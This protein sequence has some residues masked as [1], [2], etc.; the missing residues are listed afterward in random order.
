MSQP[1]RKIIAIDAMGGDNAPEAV[2]SALAEFA[3]SG[4]HFLIFGNESIREMSQRLLPKDLSYEIRYS[5]I[6]VTSDMDVMSSLRSMKDST[7]G[8]AIQ[9][10]KSGKADA[11]ISA[12]NTGLYM[13]LSK[14]ILRT[15]PG[16]DRPAIATLVPGKD[17][18]TVCLDLGANAE[19]SVKNLLDFAIVGEALARSIFDKEDVSLA[20]LNI[21][22][23]ENK[24]TELVKQTAVVL[25]KMFD[26]YVGFV[27]GD[28][29]CKGKVDVIVTDGFTGNVFLKSIEGVAK[30]IS[31]ELKETLAK[32]FLSKLGA[33]LALPALVKFRKKMDP[34]LYNGGMLL[35][36]NGI[37]VKSHGGTDKV[38]F[39]SAVRFTIEALRTNIFARIQEQLERS[40]EHF[41][42]TESK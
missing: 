18:R 27:E 26:N 31:S 38:G 13:A 4:F 37:V 24:G 40:K 8:L 17:G 30:F 10:V 22:S 41:N 35:G 42:Q 1:D 9:A 11:V 39:A 6:V 33:M 14:I 28:D 21:G 3:K 19:C 5:D 7:M 29:I 15:I 12:G 2:L 34:R 36:L 32:S 25:K 16:I 23:E 20:L